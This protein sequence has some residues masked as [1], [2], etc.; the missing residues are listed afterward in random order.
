M[1]AGVIEWSVRNRFFVLLVG[2]LIGAIGWWS[3][4]NL[5]VD[6]IPDLRRVYLGDEFRL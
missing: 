3:M 2:G 4:V 6:A 1:I 5:P